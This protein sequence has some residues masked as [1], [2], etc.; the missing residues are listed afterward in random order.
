MSITRRGFLAAG[1]GAAA[2]S[3]TEPHSSLAQQFPTK[4]L[5]IIVPYGPGGGSDIT[6]RLLA[7]DL[8]V[9]IGKPVTVENRAGGG[10]WIGWGSLAASP[11]DGYTLGYI[12]APSMFAGYLDRSQGGARKENLESFTPLMNHVID[13]NLWAVRADSKFKTVKDVIEEAKK[14]PGKL[15]ANGGGYGTDDHIAI[16]AIEANTGAKLTMVHF[17]STA[18]GKTQVL[19]GHIDILAANISEVAEDVKS[20]KVRVL[21]VMAPERSRFM[22]NAPTFREQGYNEVWA[23]SR[24]IA[25]P[26]GLPKPV[27]AALI[28]FLEKT[29]TTKEHMAKAEALSLEPRVIKGEDYRKFLKDNEQATKRLMKW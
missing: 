15:T 19:G 16:L 8:E 5:T 6:A 23:V 26:A 20:G 3:I 13:Y 25:G 29:I 18:E 27:E 1:A 4:G 12:N 14:N 2:F 21:G 11:P 28:G 17:R 9:V 24:G 10:G 7:K 22:P